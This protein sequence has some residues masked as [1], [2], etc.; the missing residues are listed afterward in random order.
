MVFVKGLN[1]LTNYFKTKKKCHRSNRKDT[2]KRQ[3]IILRHNEDNLL[4]SEEIKIKIINWCVWLKKRKIKS[5]PVRQDTEIINYWKGG[6]KQ[7]WQLI[8]KSREAKWSG[9]CE[10]NW[11]ASFKGKEI[12]RKICVAS[13]T[14]NPSE[15]NQ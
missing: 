6:E 3:S 7:K 8:Q 1:W 11:Q 5:R 2:I 4:K 10:T 12:K 14:E 15:Q 9:Q 13:Y